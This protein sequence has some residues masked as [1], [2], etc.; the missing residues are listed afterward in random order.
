MFLEED[1]FY[2]TESNQLA[3]SIIY[4]I[5]L[6]ILSSG[7][8][9]K[10]VAERQHVLRSNASLVSS[11]KHKS[12]ELVLVLSRFHG[13]YQ[14]IIIHRTCAQTDHKVDDV[15]F[16]IEFEYYYI[17]ALTIVTYMCS[18]TAQY[19]QKNSRAYSREGSSKG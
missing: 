19:R 18:V 2:P 6:W 15:F 12:S 8:E 3:H 1:D 10:R 7:K 5:Q 9:N 14:E 11:V 17:A 16:L 4:N 13:S